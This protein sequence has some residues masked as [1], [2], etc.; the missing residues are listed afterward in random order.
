MIYYSIFFLLFCSNV[1][2]CLL[3]LGDIDMGELKY[4]KKCDCK[5]YKGV[6]ILGFIVFIIVFWIDIILIF[7]F[8]FFDYLLFLIE[9][10]IKVCWY[11]DI[12]CIILIFNL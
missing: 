5:K 3:V 4:K 12:L 8:I 7:C 6:Y 2:V 1:V 10:I 11:K 9:K